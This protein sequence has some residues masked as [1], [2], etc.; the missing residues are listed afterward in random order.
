MHKRKL[1]IYR[2][3]TSI[4]D[5]LVWGWNEKDCAVFKRSYWL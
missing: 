2:G 3:P 1:L 4:A 5:W